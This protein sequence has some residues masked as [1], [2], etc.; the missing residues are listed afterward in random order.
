MNQEKTITLVTLSELMEATI[1]RDKLIEAGIPA[2]MNDENT[3][4]L[5]PVS[6]YEIKIFEKDSDT[7][8]Q[9]MG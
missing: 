3:I 6:G 2:F 7:A 9:L 4:G 1:L 8:K 5:D